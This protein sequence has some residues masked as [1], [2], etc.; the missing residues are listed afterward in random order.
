MH[1]YTL[2]VLKK[3]CIIFVVRICRLLC[4]G[5]CLETPYWSD[6]RELDRGPEQIVDRKFT[7]GSDCECSSIDNCLPVP[8]LHH[9]R[10]LRAFGDFLQEKILYCL[11]MS[12]DQLH[13]VS[14]Y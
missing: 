14:L 8:C 13:S 4:D 3:R 6:K 2:F 11:G 9:M 12:R 5:T 1:T 7:A 10:I